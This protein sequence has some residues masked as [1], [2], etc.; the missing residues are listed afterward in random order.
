MSDEDAPDDE[1]RKLVE[2]GAVEAV[3]DGDEFTGDDHLICGL[4]DEDATPET[5]GEDNVLAYC[6]ACGRKCK[7]KVWMP[8]EPMR[9]C[10]DCALLL[11]RTRRDAPKLDI[12]GIFKRRREN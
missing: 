3:D 9:I 12:R 11:L 8:R 4:A 7:H 5:I 6:T 2:Q 10:Q 1:V